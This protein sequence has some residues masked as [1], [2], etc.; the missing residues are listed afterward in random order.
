M[1]EM[2]T[3]SIARL[4]RQFFISYFK[5]PMY[6]VSNTQS[7]G[8]PSCLGENE[9]QSAQEERQ[10]E[11]KYLSSMKIQHIHRCY[12]LDE[13]PYTRTLSDLTRQGELRNGKPVLSIFRR[14][15]QVRE[16]LRFLNSYAIF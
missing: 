2:G 10:N 5:G 14:I 6:H 3:E 1:P 9:A 13:M 8:P 4:A 7:H 12:E 11:T 16:L 15:W